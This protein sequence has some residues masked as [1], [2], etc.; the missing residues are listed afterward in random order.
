M[1]D[2]NPP[3]TAGNGPSGH[4]RPS[5][6]VER[7]SAAFAAAWA[8]A[9]K[10]RCTPGTVDREARMQMWSG[11]IADEVCRARAEAFNEAA[12]IAEARC[13]DFV[14]RLA[15]LLETGGNSVEMQARAS[16]SARI[17]AEIRR[18]AKS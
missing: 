16:E 18:R 1:S 8:I 13:A 6:G 4:D 9:D 2:G 5:G 17:A 11:L 15:A 3:E 10:I 14:E 12:R 7:W